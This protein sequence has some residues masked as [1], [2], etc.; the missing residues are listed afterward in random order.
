MKYNYYILLFLLSY[1]TLPLSLQVLGR[2]VYTSNAQLGG[3]QVMHN[4]GVSHLTAP[5][6]FEGVVSIVNWLAYVPKVSC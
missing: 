2:E 3:I 1:I 4:N 5:T 6:D